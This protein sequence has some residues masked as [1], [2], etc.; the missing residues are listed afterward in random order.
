MSDASD[1]AGEEFLHI[2]LD[3]TFD[4]PM[5]ARSCVGQAVEVKLEE[6]PVRAI[7]CLPRT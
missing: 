2:A 3:M 1:A 4:W 6:S 5:I 7:L